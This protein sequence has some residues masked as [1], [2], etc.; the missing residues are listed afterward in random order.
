MNSSSIGFLGSSFAWRVVST[1]DC[2]AAYLIFRVGLAGTKLRKFK[3]CGCSG[4]FS[5][6]FN[7]TGFRLTCSTNT[8]YALLYF[9]SKFWLASPCWRPAVSRL[10]IEFL[11]SDSCRWYSGASLSR[12]SLL[13]RRPRLGVTLSKMSS[14]SSSD[15]CSKAGVYR[16]NVARKRVGIC[17]RC[18]K[19]PL[20]T[21][22]SFSMGLCCLMRC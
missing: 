22:P 5:G 10:L 20:L 14:S 4:A 15:S 19:S 8:S 17:R 13:L 6:N 3:A 12:S 1:T 9:L 21:T 16:W 11:F 18:W 7:G 2:Y